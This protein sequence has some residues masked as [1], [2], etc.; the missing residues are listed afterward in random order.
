MRRDHFDLGSTAGIGR[1][2]RCPCDS[3]KKYKKCYADPRDEPINH[4]PFDIAAIDRA[5]RQAEA[6]RTRHLHSRGLDAR[7]CWSRSAGNA[8]WLSTSASTIRAN[9]CRSTTSCVTIRLAWP[10]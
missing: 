5:R 3:G 7:F 9:G 10:C 1:N 8:S 6:L 2:R 4:P